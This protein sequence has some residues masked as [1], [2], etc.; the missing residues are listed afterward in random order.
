MHLKYI[1]EYTF[2]HFWICF[3]CIQRRKHSFISVLRKL[4]TEQVMIRHR[5]Q[6]IQICISLF[7]KWGKS[8][9][10]NSGYFAF[11]QVNCTADEIIL[12]GISIEEKC[13][14]FHHYY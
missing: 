11:G 8:D 12:K 9:K 5:W 6:S 3:F 2:E 14:S 1:F 13:G 7:M 4:G 10:N